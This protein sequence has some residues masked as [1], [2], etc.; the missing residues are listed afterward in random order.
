MIFFPTNDLRKY[1]PGYILFY[2]L[3]CIT[4]IVLP[5]HKVFAFFPFVFSGM[6]GVLAL[7]TSRS[8]W[9]SNGNWAV[10]L[11]CILFASFL[12]GYFISANTDM[13]WQYLE[14]KLY[15]LITPV[16]FFLLKPLSPALIK[17]LATLFVFSCLAFIATSLGVACYD[18]IALGKV[19]F[20]YKELVGFSTMHPSYL[21]MYINFCI[22][23]A[24]VEYFAIRETASPAKRNQLL[25]ILSIFFIYLLLLTAKTAIIIGVV[26]IIFLFVYWG[27]KTGKMQ[28]A[29]GYL[30]AAFILLSI[31][32]LSN[33]EIR[34]RVGMLF[35]YREVQ[36]E[37]SVLSRQYQWVSAVQLI[38]DTHWQG[39]G[40]DVSEDK[41]VEYYAKNNFQKGVDERY[42]THNQFLQAAVDGGWPA[43]LLM[44]FAFASLL[45]SARRK[46]RT[47]QYILLWIILI[48]L[49]TECIF[50]TLSG[51][52][53]ITLFGVLH[54]FEQPVAGT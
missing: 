30:T 20:F 3:L 47:L 50:Q 16:L 37:N 24:G 8:S 35:T 41:L 4:V 23:I 29:I 1:S 43:L 25:I 14:S 53:F 33:S 49:L 40:T 52:V 51:I 12:P 19:H 17:Y 21:G 48:S 45:F 42:N 36:N 5:F 46:R 28:L 32:G 11:W 7:I 13:A 39:V 22:A 44:L 26:S 15:L 27:Y 6:A 34:N 18:L 31:I 38:Q 54:S 10:L 2:L 9:R